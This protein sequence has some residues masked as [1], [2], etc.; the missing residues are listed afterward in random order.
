MLPR[1]GVVRRTC[2]LYDIY[3]VG[4]VDEVGGD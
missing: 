2:V 1:P 3:G 4:G